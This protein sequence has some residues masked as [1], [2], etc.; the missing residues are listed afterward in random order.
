MIDSSCYHIY[1]ALKLVL[2]KT[3]KCDG[4]WI[5]EDFLITVIIVTD[6]D[7]RDF[8]WPTEG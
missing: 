4:K 2:V 8:V 7:K 3:N 5:E 1:F 6:L